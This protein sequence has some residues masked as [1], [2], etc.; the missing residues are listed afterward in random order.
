M[1]LVMQNFVSKFDLLKGY[2]QVPL[3]H[4]ARE[5]SA[6]VTP[7]GLFAYRVMPFGLRNAPATFQRLMNRVL[8]DMEGCTV[9]LDDVVVF[10][11]SW[12]QH[13]EHIRALFGCLAEARLTVNL[14]KC[15]FARATVTYLGRVVGQGCVRPVAAKVSAVENYPAPTTKKELLRFLG[16]VGYYRCF[17]RNF[18]TVASPLTNLL[19]ASVMYVWTPECQEAFEAIKALLCT[20]P[21]LSAPRFDRPFSLQ[22]DASHVGAGAVLLQVDD[23]G[24]DKPVSFFSPK[25]LTPTS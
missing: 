15:E 3:T 23:L 21:V 5:I 25:S 11:D 22:V 16:L 13:V 17:C 8:G 10:S 20:A 2:W 7:N 1:R 4:R 12:S 24:V 6:F 14:S 19:K 18:S 9:Y